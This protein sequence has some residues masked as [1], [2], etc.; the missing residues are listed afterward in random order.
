MEVVGLYQKGV[1]FE[2]PAT[3]H[4][5]RGLNIKSTGICSDLSEQRDEPREGVV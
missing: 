2:V 5:N 4:E 3:K 1:L